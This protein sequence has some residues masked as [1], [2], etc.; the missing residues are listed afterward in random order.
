LDVHGISIGFL[1]SQAKKAKE[2]E[3][4]GGFGNRGAG[5]EGK[6]EEN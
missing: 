2:A 6:L 1:L 4:V 5:R 3:K